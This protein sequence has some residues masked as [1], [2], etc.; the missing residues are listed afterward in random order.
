MIE[1]NYP[2]LPRRVMARAP[3]S[4]DDLEYALSRFSGNVTR[5]VGVQCTSGPWC[6]SSVRLVVHCNRRCARAASSF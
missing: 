6:R 4:Q 2:H 1:F 5:G 3:R